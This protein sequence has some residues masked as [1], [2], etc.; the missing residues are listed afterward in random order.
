MPSIAG[1]IKITNISSGGIFNV[2]DAL[3]ISPKS[4]SKTFAGSGSF[5][6]GD[7]LQTYNAASSTNT[8]DPDLVDTSNTLNQ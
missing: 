5:N 3:N 4:S 1:P 6:T 2:G 8:I 7:W